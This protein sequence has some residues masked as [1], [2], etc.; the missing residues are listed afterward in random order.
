M[1]IV[2]VNGSPEVRGDRIYYNVVLGNVYY[3]FML[4]CFRPEMSCSIY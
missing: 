4:N 1:Q 2:K 3:E